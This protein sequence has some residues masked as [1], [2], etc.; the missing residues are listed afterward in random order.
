MP[1][2]VITWDQFTTRSRRKH[3]W[4]RKKIIQL[5]GYIGG[6]DIPEE[7]PEKKCSIF[8]N[9]MLKQFIFGRENLATSLLQQGCGPWILSK[10]KGYINILFHGEL[11]YELPCGS[12]RAI[13]GLEE[14]IWNEISLFG[15]D[16]YLVP[17]G[18]LEDEIFFKII[19]CL[20]R[21]LRVLV[22]M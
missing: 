15:K 5:D 16:Y 9:H 8:L 4:K 19:G 2:A 20:E 22:N 14:S 17:W 18:K 13:K 10:K 3:F 6:Y 7:N 12:L 1:V 21:I 11:H